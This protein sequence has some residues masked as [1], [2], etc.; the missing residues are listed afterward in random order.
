MRFNLAV[1]YFF[2]TNAILNCLSE[3]DLIGCVALRR[4][5]VKHVDVGTH[6]LGKYLSF[7]FTQDVNTQLP[8]SLDPVAPN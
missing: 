2:M 5:N 1:G 4:Q 3:T 6:L 7:H 8:N